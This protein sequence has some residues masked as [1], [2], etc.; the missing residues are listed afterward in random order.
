MNR[1][2]GE[3]K[4]QELE[5]KETGGKKKVQYQGTGTK[6]KELIILG[7]TSY[8]VS[9]GSLQSSLQYPVSGVQICEELRST[10]LSQ[11]YEP[12]N[13]NHINHILGTVCRA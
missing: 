10:C 1:R 12:P 4:D 6:E 13:I 3:K 5:G 2:K 7:A 8:L 9:A 11:A